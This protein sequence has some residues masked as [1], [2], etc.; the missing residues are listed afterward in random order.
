M[1]HTAEQYR[2][3]ATSMLPYGPA[4]N[5]SRGSLM[6]RFWYAIGALMS[7][8]EADLAK[9]AY[10]T[11]IRRTTELLSEWERD[12]GLESDPS[13]SVEERRARLLRLSNRKTFPSTAGL[14]EL[15]ADVGYTI[16]VV[17]HK[18]FV[19]G[20]LRCQ[21]G[22]ADWETG[23]TRSVIGIIVTDVTGGLTRDEFLDYITTFLPAHVNVTVVYANKQ[24]GK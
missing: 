20:D 13:L 24:K 18:P 22:N 21:C 19:C 4:W 17:R 8:L 5:R 1:T 3:A 9:I 11:R 12:Y 15:A 23:V 16:K 2:D 10:E 7:V 6:W 14:E